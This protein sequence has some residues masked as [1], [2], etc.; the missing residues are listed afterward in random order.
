M[1]S[2][3]NFNTDNIYELFMDYLTNEKNNIFRFLGQGSSKAC[4]TFFEET[5]NEF[6]VVKIEKDYYIDDIL[7]QDLLDEL[8]F[9]DIDED[10][11]CYEQTKKEIEMYKWAKENNLDL[12]LAPI[13]LEYSSAD[14]QFEVM[15]YCEDLYLKE[16]NE[17]KPLR[18]SIK[19]TIKNTIKCPT[20]GNTIGG[21]IIDYLIVNG[22]FSQDLIKDLYRIGKE[23]LTVNGSLF[24]DAG[25][26]SNLGIYNG[27]LVLR[28]YGYGYMD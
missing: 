10:N 21:F 19:N 17:D 25:R 3:I 20:Y 15:G 23:L 24:G 1:K 9:L 2:T 28:D 5:T 7:N 22:G 11:E 18:E 12:F 8:T 16:L 4:F 27:K 6:Y 14:Q 26:I 13:L